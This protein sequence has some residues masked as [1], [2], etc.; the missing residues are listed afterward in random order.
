VS[1]LRCLGIDG[2]NNPGYCGRE[3]GTFWLLQRPPIGVDFDVAAIEDQYATR[4]GFVSRDGKKLKVSLQSQLTLAFI[5]GGQLREVNAK[6]KLKLPCDVWRGML[7][8]DGADRLSKEACLSRLR[9]RCPAL[10]S[11]SDDETEAYG[12]AEAAEL[13]G[14]Q[15]KGVLRGGQA[16]VARKQLFWEDVRLVSVRSKAK[17]FGKAFAKGLK[18]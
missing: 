3:G 17:A 7:W 12:I 14:L 10:Q 8:S 6:R 18:K 11:A 1:S 16:W 2:G 15:K 9:E 13:I 5:A 4:S